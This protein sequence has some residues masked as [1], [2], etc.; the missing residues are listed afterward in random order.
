MASISPCSSTE[1]HLLFLNPLSLFLV[2]DLLLLTPLSLFLTPLSLFLNSLSLF[3]V[4]H[5][6]RL[7]GSFQLERSTTAVSCTPRQTA[8]CFERH[9]H[10]VPSFESNRLTEIENGEKAVD[11][12]W[13]K[14]ERGACCGEKA[15]DAEWPKSER[16]ACCGE[17]VSVERNS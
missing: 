16:R 11:A 6:E 9:Y 2:S 14:S 7:P 10:P 1:P 3:P 5:P 8:C 12:E 4:S 13:P 15:V 17:N